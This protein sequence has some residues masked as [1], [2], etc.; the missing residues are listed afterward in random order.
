MSAPEEIHAAAAPAASVA[1]ATKSLV[2]DVQQQ[3][4]STIGNIQSQN[5]TL[6]DVQFVNTAYIGAH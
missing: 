1:D 6:T 2:A 4:F 5:F 3:L